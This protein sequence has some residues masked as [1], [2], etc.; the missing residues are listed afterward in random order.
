MK[1]SVRQDSILAL[2]SAIVLNHKDKELIWQ[3]SPTDKGYVSTAFDMFEEINGYWSFLPEE[4][5]EQ[6][7]NTYQ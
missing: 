3:I 5:V 6:I 1:L 4:K 2:R 7:F